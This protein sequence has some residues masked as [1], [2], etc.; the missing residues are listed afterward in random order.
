MHSVG[1][2]GFGVRLAGLLASVC[3]DMF[4]YLNM[5]S[6]FVE[7]RWSDGRILAESLR[8]HRF[9]V[10][11]IKES[12][13]GGVRSLHSVSCVFASIMGARANVPCFMIPVFEHTRICV[14]SL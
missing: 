2:V 5:A 9:R 10:G 12:S 1:D 4:G 6:K 3:M 7:V 14:E 13:S 8:T 11:L